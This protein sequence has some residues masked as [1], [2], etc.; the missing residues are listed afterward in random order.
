MGEEVKPV[1]RRIYETI[2]FDPEIGTYRAVC[3]RIEYP[4]GQFH[5]IYVPLEK[6]DPEKVDE[7]VRDWLRKYGKWVGREVPL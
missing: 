2:A 7:Y 1:I 4:T 3:I 6:Y 5:D